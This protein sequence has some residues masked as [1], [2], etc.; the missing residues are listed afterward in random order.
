MSVTP[1]DAFKYGFVKQ[2]KDAGLTDNQITER[3]ELAL[4]HVEKKATPG[5]LWSSLQGMWDS[6]HAPATANAAGGGGEPAFNKKLLLA[7][8]G[9]PL[10]VG[11]GAG[12][13]ASKLKGNFVDDEDVKNQ[14]VIDELRR[15]TELAKQNQRAARS[16]IS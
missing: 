2:C 13:M 4:A 14:E 10:A 16:P 15:Q 7:S 6:A 11:A 8:A 12:M 9:I 1:R 5:A 3:A